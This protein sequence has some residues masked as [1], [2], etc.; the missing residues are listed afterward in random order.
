MSRLREKNTFLAIE[1]AFIGRKNP[2]KFTQQQYA[3]QI[4]QISAERFIDII[5]F[6]SQLRFAVNVGTNI[7]N[8]RKTKNKLSYY[9]SD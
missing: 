4:E 3:S 8:A 1:L 9:C 7:S 5:F 2:N 6:K